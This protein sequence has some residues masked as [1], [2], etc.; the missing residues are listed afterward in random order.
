MGKSSSDFERFLYANY[1]DDYRRATVENVPDD[2]LTAILSRHARHYQ[3][4]CEIPEWIKNVYRDK[5]P[6]EVLN[7]NETVKSFVQKEQTNKKENE[8]ETRR[9]IDYGVTL[10]ALGYASETVA[11]LLENRQIREQLLKQAGTQ[12]LTGALFEKWIQTRE[13]DMQ[14]IEKDW[15][16]NSPEKY[17]F[18]LVK[19]ISKREK[20][21]GKEGADVATLSA[22]SSA[23]EQQLQD[24][25]G[26]MSDKESK[27]KM[28]DYLRQAP[29]QAALRH[30]QPKSM[31]LFTS[32]LED[33]GLKLKPMAKNND[34][35]TVEVEN[36]GIV[37]VLKGHYERFQKMRGLLVN[38]YSYQNISLG[39]IG[40]RAVAEAKTDDDLDR[41][42]TLRRNAKQ[43]TA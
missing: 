13:S 36:E 41:M 2:V 20:K 23:L 12:P 14:A 7:G 6:T 38:K 27:R 15:Q 26:N 21:L 25:M 30:L 16:E 4:W 34:G 3:I 33:K 17:I 37:G 11:T 39:L 22:E 24:F 18:H 43:K 42:M 19:E 28:I 31:S 9:L 29:Q 10:L 1:P 8:D 35:Q 32:L 5:L 40:A